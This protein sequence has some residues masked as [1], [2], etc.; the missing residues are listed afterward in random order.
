MAPVGA[1]ALLRW[2]VRPGYRAQIP[3]LHGFPQHLF[4]QPRTRGLVLRSLEFGGREHYRV[5]TSL[6]I[7]DRHFHVDVDTELP[8]EVIWV[9]KS[10]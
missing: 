1:S 9:G 5:L 2:P 7:Y 10:R 4:R 3:P 8:T 6:G